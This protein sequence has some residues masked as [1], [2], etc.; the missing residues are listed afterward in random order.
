MRR[1]LKSRHRIAGWITLMTAGPVALALVAATAPVAA[2][3]TAPVAAAGTAPV[4]RTPA[5]GTPA[6]SSTVPNQRVLQ[7]VPC[8]DRMYAVGDFTAITQGGSVVTRHGVMSFL[9]AAPFT[10]TSFAPAVNGVVATI[11]FNG[12]DCSSAYIGGS[13]TAVN[14]TAVANLA[15]ISTTTGD[16]VKAFGHNAN[17]RVETLLVTRGHLLAGGSFTKINGSA[18]TAYAS[19]QPASGRVETYLSQAFSGRYEFPDAA[20]NRTRVASQELSRQGD[21]VVVTG[22]FTSVAGVHREQ[23]AVLA[24]GATQAT[25]TGW[26]AP[27]LFAHCA[28]SQPYYARAAAWSLDGSTLYLAATGFRPHDEPSGRGP[29]TG[30]CDSV[31][32]FSSAAGSVRHKWI[33]YTGCDSLYSVTADASTVYVGGH[34]RWMSNSQA[35]NKAGPGAVEAP[36]LAGVSVGSGALSWNPTRSRGFGATDLVMRPAGLWVASDNGF[37]AD[38]CGGVKGLAGICFLPY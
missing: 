8:G 16:V 35:C 5:T 31:S 23:V 12:P 24:L 1:L 37:G 32:A 2:A 22:V 20:R 10:L 36:G 21:R 33:N 26:V 29:R 38:Q 11:A 19:L 3:G 14:G 34:Q 7:L 18:R 17:A 28:K 25:L 27:E 9:A 13:F 30:L 6:L 4:S 15:K